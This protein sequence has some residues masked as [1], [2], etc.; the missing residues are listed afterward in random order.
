MA[1]TQ[2]P[3]LLL[4]ETGFIIR[5]LLLGTFADALTERR[6]LVVAVPDPNDERLRNALADKRL[7]LIPFHRAPTAGG[8]SR[9]DQLR[10]WHT[11]MY[12]F[13]EGEK[14]TESVKLQ[15]RLFGSPTS[16]LGEAATRVL[17][18]TGRMLRRAQLMGVVEDRYLDSVA[19]WPVA[20]QW[21]E[22]LARLR[23]AAIVSTMLT[24][25]TNRRPSA[26]LPVVIAA[27]QQSVPSGTLVQSWDN[28]SS[29]TAVLPPWLDRYWTWSDA[30]SQELLSL[31]PRITADRV[32]VVGSPQFDFH[33]R[34]ELLEP[35][36]QYLPRLGLDPALPYVVI[37]TG[38][39]VWMPNEPDT[40]ARMVVA[41]RGA[42][43]RCQV[44]IRLHPKDDGARWEPLLPILR[45]HG[46]ALQRT[47]PPV[48]MDLGGFVPPREFYRDQVN[49]L[50]HAAV[51]LNT[52]STLTVD[53]AILDRPVICIGYD[54]IAD[55]RFPE[56]RALAY[57]RSTHYSHLVQT[58][59]V[60]VVH[61]EQEC[62]QAIGHYL[63][64]PA[65][66]RDGRRRIAVTVTGEADGGA[67]KRLADDVLTLCDAAIA[68]RSAA[69]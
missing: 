28:L 11:Y 47:S 41:I 30:M 7:T 39:Q 42:M 34:P 22:E 9:L 43:P 46:A 64:D 51:V 1:A 58:G 38:T 36:E 35:R 52:A 18:N 45:A 5:N 37:G 32:R 13:K 25:A 40:V 67:G 59:G 17:T 62:V 49:C 8:T 20:K 60:W 57:S 63:E 54:V 3:V 33:R 27:R 12:R 26:D 68:Q 16:R 23:P 15:N 56:G 2:Q 53:A 19:R 66:H 50:A 14:G 69:S 4:A 10:T 65:L 55:A 29:K 6:P 21:G 31:N 48:H 24:H 61:S 44:L